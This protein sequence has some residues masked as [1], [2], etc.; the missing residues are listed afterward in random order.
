MFKQ[1]SEELN[2]VSKQYSL[3][4]IRKEEYKSIN[5]VPFRIS[6]NPFKLTNMQI[7]SLN[8]IGYLICKYIQ[9]VIQLYNQNLEVKKILDRGKSADFLNFKNVQYLFLRPDLIIDKDDNFKVCE[10]ETSI[11][12]LALADILNKAYL[13]CGI[14]TLLS[15]DSLSK[16]ILLNIPKQGT[17]A[18]SERVKAFHG[19]LEYLAKN[20]FNW[21][22]RLVDDTPIESYNIYRAFYCNDS[23]SDNN[24]KLL[25]SKNKNF[26]PS[27]T[28]QFEEKAIL[29]FIWDKRFKSY[30]KDTLGL[31]DY[32][33]LRKIIPPTFIVGQ[34]D[35]F[36]LGLPNGVNN[37]LDIAELPKS[38]RR[39]VLKKSGDSSWGEGILF[40]HKISHTR[41]R[42][43]LKKAILSDELY[44]IQ[45]FNE[46][47]KHSITYFSDT[48]VVE[49]KAKIRLTPYYGFISQFGKMIAIKATGC[50]NTDYIHGASNSINTSVS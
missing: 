36:E 16:Y 28:P 25:T 32:N 9:I 12:G 48:E 31:H 18:Y 3:Y 24:I 43:A 35:N 15:A 10:I 44:V 38:K 39:L 21:G 11:F 45:E 2:R 49:M 4:E 42:E 41:I 33:E 20:I 27:L 22:V 14:E 13:S 47:K 19:Q 50:E 1:I 46:A 34:E 8:K 29:S 26:I 37:L 5:D 40:L 23:V 30:F 17:I 6:P 7:A